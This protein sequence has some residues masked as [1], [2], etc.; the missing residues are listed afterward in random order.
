VIAWPAEG[1]TLDPGLCTVFGFAW[2]G[3]APIE[4]VEV[5]LDDDQGTW[6]PAR[7]LHG[8]GPLAWTR[9]ELD[10]SAPAGQ[11]VRLHVRAT[12]AAGNV[13]P[14]QAGWN[15]FGYEQNAIMAREVQIRAS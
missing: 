5:S 7:L 8:S 2:S 10:W 12:D 6:L 4:R 11:R 13:Q 15:K 1:A 3:H 9:W 14:A